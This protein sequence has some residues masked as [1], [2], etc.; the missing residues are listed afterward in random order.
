MAQH[1]TF[2]EVL[3]LVRRLPPADRARLV[4]EISQTKRSNGPRR[5]LLGAY[6]GLGPTPSEE[7]SKE[8]RR[9][10]WKNLGEED[11]G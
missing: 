1:V 8:V 6:A 5:S 11:L 2:A 7:D 10:M 3:D 9:E 4:E